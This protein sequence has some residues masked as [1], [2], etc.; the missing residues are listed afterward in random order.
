MTDAPVHSSL[1]PAGLDATIVMLRHGESAWV[2]EGR[3][4]GQGDSPLSPEGIRQAELAATRIA[5]PAIVPSLPIPG[6][7][8]LEIRHSP[9][10][11]TAATA[12]AVATAIAA[13]E[14]APQGAPVR[15]RLVPDT[16]FLEIGQGDWEGRFIDRDR[17][18]L[19]R[20][21]GRLATRSADDLG[22]RR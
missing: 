16:G 5:H 7:R 4:Q 22:T 18:A 11:R 14:A 10:L 21:P 20:R 15:L 13:S 3:F 6:G 8:P 1:I 9:L 12:R 17:G 19:G 2:S